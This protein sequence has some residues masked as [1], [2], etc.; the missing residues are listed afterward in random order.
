ML[1]V[2]SCGE[3]FVRLLVVFVVAP[4]ML[5]SSALYGAVQGGIQSFAHLYTFCGETHRID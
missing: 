2:S 5:L 1:I 4:T 3:I